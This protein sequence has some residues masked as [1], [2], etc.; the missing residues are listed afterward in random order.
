MLRLFSSFF[1]LAFFLLVAWIVLCFYCIYL[2]VVASFFLRCCLFF[3]QAYGSWKSIRA[4][5]N[6]STPFVSCHWT[7]S[8]EFV[9]FSFPVVYFILCC[10]LSL[11]LCFVYFLC[12]SWLFAFVSP[13]FLRVSVAFSWNFCRFFFISAWLLT[14]PHKTEN[15]WRTTATPWSASR[16]L[17]WSSK[18]FCCR[19]MHSFVSFSFFSFSFHLLFFLFWPLSLWSVF[20]VMFSIL[21]SPFSTSHFLFFFFLLKTWSLVFD[22]PWDATP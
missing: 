9:S 19:F 14:H 12:C 5:G 8:S 22:C 1:Y 18:V 2:F 3:L 6:A 11:R 16:W 7:G 17:R 15:T 4:Q 10:F 21:S 13:V 20:I